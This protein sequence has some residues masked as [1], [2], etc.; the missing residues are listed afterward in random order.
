[1]AKEK[2]FVEQ[3]TAMDVDFTAWYTDVVKKADLAAY[4]GVLTDMLYG[5]ISKSFL[6][7]NSRKRGMK[8]FICLCLSPNLC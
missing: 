4:S 8:I 6:M 1:M 3:I 7:L 2:K 5:K